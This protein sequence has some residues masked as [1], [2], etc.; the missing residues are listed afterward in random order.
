MFKRISST[1]LSFVILPMSTLAQTAPRPLTSDNPPK[2]QELSNLFFN[3][4]V[5]V[6]TIAGFASFLALIFGG[7]RYITAQGDPKAT[8][9][10]RG[11]ITWAV[12]GLAFI[13]IAW[14][15]LSFIAEFTGLPLTT[16]CLPRVSGGA[17]LFC[18]P[19]LAF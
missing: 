10:A 16:F 3:A 2:I 14:L 9:S 12:V 11:I 7:F 8:A 1:I 13:I 6:A 15:I 19:E 17:T 4:I 5:V 18:S